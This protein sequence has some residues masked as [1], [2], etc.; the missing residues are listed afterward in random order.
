M[1]AK[2]IR[3]DSANRK[4]NGSAT[5]PVRLCRSSVL[6]RSLLARPEREELAEDL[7]VHH[8][9]AHQRRQHRQ[10]GQADDPVA[11][12]LPG[13]VQAV[14]HRIEEPAADRELVVAAARLPSRGSMVIVAVNVVVRHRSEFGT[15]KLDVH[16]STGSRCVVYALQFDQRQFVG[17]RP[18]DALRGVRELLRDRARSSRETIGAACVERRHRLRREARLRATAQRSISRSNTDSEPKKNATI[19]TK[20]STRPNQ[21][22]SQVIDSRKDGTSSVRRVSQRC[23]RAARPAPVMSAPPPASTL[24]TRARLAAANGPAEADQEHQEGKQVEPGLRLAVWQRPLSRAMRCRGD[25]T[26]DEDIAAQHA[27]GHARDHPCG[28]C[29][30]RAHCIGTR[31]HTPAT[32][33]RN[34]N[35]NASPRRRWRAARAA[36]RRGHRSLGQFSCGGSGQAWGSRWRTR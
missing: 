12:V 34:T 1:P 29:S 17:Q 32:T 23:A 6:R 7:A 21:V 4:W 27:G 22:C 31:M 11:Q 8:D 36:G 2:M 19:S 16:R 28:R 14:V 13:E 26:P 25:E 35:Q 5:T 18:R 20:P 24:H 9:A 30:L 15:A 10:R 3:P 33:A